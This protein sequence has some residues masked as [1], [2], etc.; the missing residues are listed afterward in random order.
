MN[1]N[2]MIARPMRR[3]SA[4]TGFTLIEL[5]LVMV[6]LAILAAV[7]V[8]KFTGR[9]EQAKQSRALQDITN[10]KAQLNTFE[11]DTGSFPTSL[12]QLRENSANVA[13]WHGPYIDKPVPQDPW[14]HDYIYHAPTGESTEFQVLSAGP[15]GQEGTADDIK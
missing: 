13:N 14:G 15:D 8:P 9:T 1:R 3:S 10:L 2:K 5:L 7:I 4:P 6:I 11:V 12:D